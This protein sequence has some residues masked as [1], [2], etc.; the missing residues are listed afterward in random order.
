MTALAIVCAA[1]AAVCGALG[2]CLQH[3]GVQSETVGGGLRTRTVGRLLRNRSWIVG[4]STLVLCVV[5]QV[6][7][8]SFAPVVVVAPIVAL[9]LPIVTALGARAGSTRIGGTTG[10][11]VVA[12]TLAV[13]VFVGLAADMAV[14]TSITRD[15]LFGVARLVGL[16]VVGLAGFGALARGPLRCS[17]FAAAAGVSY[18]LVSILIHDIGYAVRTDGLAGVSP[19]SLLGA[20]AAFLAG[21]WLVQLGY[22]S[23]PADVVVGF[24]TVFNPLVATAIGMIMLGEV[25][26][27]PEPILGILLVCAAVAVTGVAVL[28]GRQ[29]G[30]VPWGDPGTARADRS[31]RREVLR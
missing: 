8:L 12:T 30:A 1:A 23:G 6:L 10:T 22:S 3:T 5:L 20:A 25:S 18:G 16:A 7:A 15:T 24:Y 28:A 31:D 13:V 2:A 19:W 27:V 11:A 9:S 29:P 17:A 21:S 14:G 4:T 26:G